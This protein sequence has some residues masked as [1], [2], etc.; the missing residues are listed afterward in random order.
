MTSNGT[1][2]PMKTRQPDVAAA[3]SETEPSA[4]APEPPTAAASEAEPSAPTTDDRSEAGDVDTPED[5]TSTRG[6]G[7]VSVSVRG[8]VTGAVIAALVAAVAALGWLYIDARRQLDAHALQS[9]NAAHAE[10]VALDYA[11]NAATMD[12]KDLQSWHVKLVA[13]T[14]PEL[15]KK[16]SDAGASME[17]VLVPLQW[18]STAQPLVAKVRSNA[19]GIYVVDSF[20]SVQTKTVQAPEALQSTATYSTTIDSNK[21]WQITDVGGIGSALGP[22]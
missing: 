17:Q 22:K 18:S 11:V 7:S 19:G 10:K 12:F 2:T 20:V 6:Q 3:A 1:E 9:A 4:A 13:G 5:A 16:L 15:N 21:N 8:L 14:S